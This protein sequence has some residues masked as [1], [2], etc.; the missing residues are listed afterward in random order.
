VPPSGR[1]AQPPLVPLQPLTLLAS[2]VG[3]T[4]PA[5]FPCGIPGMAVA[6]TDGVWRAMAVDMQRGADSLDAALTYL[7]MN[8][9]TARADSLVH[10]HNTQRFPNDTVSGAALLKPAMLAVA[11][12]GE[13]VSGVKPTGS[14]A[15]ALPSMLFAMVVHFVATCVWDRT[16]A[17]GQDEFMDI[18]CRETV[19]VAPAN[20]N[21]ARC[22]MV[23]VLQ[24]LAC[25]LHAQLHGDTFVVFRQTLQRHLH[26]Q[27]HMV[28]SRGGHDSRDPTTVLIGSAIGSV[29]V[30]DVAA[31]RAAWS[32]PADRAPPRR[33]PRTLQKKLPDS[34]DDSITSPAE[35]LILSQ[36]AARRYAE[37]QRKRKAPEGLA[38]AVRAMRPPPACR[39]ASTNTEPVPT[40]DSDSDSNS[41]SNSDS[42]S[43]G[44]DDG[45]EE[46]IDQLAMCYTF[47]TPRQLRCRRCWGV[48]RIK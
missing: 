47:A 10:A 48:H 26:Q 45:A 30:E 11:S 38:G 43:D 25:C 36:R 13:C 16:D 44:N 29:F 28:L 7:L 20:A 22:V 2:A 18:M 23:R 27:Q 37:L 3:M 4:A 41:D 31:L 24:A 33:L 14:A 39:D 19:A 46:N 42:D 21:V 1:T 12:G 40:A 5:V 35:Q 34:G 17:V 6:A 15:G 32:R 9:N 8:G